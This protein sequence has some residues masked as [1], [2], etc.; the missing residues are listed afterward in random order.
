MNL[1]E[2]FLNIMRD[3]LDNEYDDFFKSFDVENVKGIRINPLKIDK[4]VFLDKKLFNLKSVPWCN[5]GF[6][7]AN[8]DIE[9]PAKHPYY[10][11]GLYYIQEP[12]AMIPV[13]VL[14]PQPGDRVLD[15]AAAPGGKTTQIGAK[16]QN[17][18]IIVSN[19]ISPKRVKPLEKNINLFGIKNS[20]ILND[21]P[22]KIKNYF[23]NYF[24]K[25]LIDAPCSGEG[26]FKRDKRAISD[27]SEDNNYQLSKI[28]R[29]ILSD[30]APMVKPGGKLVYSTCTFS[31]I[32]NE[33]TIDW[34]INEFPNFEIIDINGFES[35]SPAMPHLINANVEIS[36]ARR[37]WPH[38]INGDGHFIALLQRKNENIYVN[39][40]ST[41]KPINNL[42]PDELSL[43]QD[44]FK[45]T[46]NH[47][48]ENITKIKNRVYIPTNVDKNLSGLRVITN[49][50]Y[51]GELKKNRFIPSQQYA[52]TLK[53]EKAKKVVNISSED[54]N[55]YKY[56]K[57]ETLIIDNE[58]GWNLIC[59]DGYPCGWAKGNGSSLKNY[60]EPSW[61]MG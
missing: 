5:E 16:L 12:S 40:N 47:Y 2:N 52:M 51:L 8:Y 21:N 50:I 27:W 35:L 32:E 48:E 39:K 22:E 31:L 1:P 30:I 24:D 9:R 4:E 34:F 7:L 17:K 54:I 46:L 55:A 53:M 19:D 13:E 25:I 57:G 60:Y 11:C 26:M 6:Y 29:K 33:G 56:L 41:Y 59:I 10:H 43:V 45:E 61:R 37:A 49:G 38:K 44:F 42:S 20:I 3:I 23:E 58:K 28:Q 36:K 18:G 14:D 15:I